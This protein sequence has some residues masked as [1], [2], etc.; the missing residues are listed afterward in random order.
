M[1]NCFVLDS[2][3]L[4]T[5]FKQEAGH[6]TVK[7][8]LD[9]AAAGEIDIWLTEINWGEIYYVTTRERGE[10]DGQRVLN[11]LASLPLHYWAASR[12][13]VLAAARIKARYP[14]SYAD[15]F[16][17][18]AA[19]ELDCP[20]VTGDPEFRRVERAGAVKVVWLRE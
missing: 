9:K 10:I 15:A 13:R 16:A 11:A 1:N 12:D 6:R 8:L 7:Q 2:Y 19:R 3:A 14:V 17:I 4:F 20:V 18:A 5:F